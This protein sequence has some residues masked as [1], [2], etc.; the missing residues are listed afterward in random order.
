MQPLLRCTSPAKRY[1][2]RVGVVCLSW[3]FPNTPI[4]ADG[5]G[6]IHP[7]WYGD[8]DLELAQ[9]SLNSFC[10][11]IATRHR[12][13]TWDP[14]DG[15]SVLLG[16]WHGIMDRV[17]SHLN[18]HVLGMPPGHILKTRVFPQWGLCNLGNGASTLQKTLCRAARG[19]MPMEAMPKHTYGC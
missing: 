19:G 2:R 11:P 9:E 17:A 4:G 5:F 12:T 7:I 3:P 15:P 14:M 8:P 1:A 10:R 18:P 13:L 16:L 6:N